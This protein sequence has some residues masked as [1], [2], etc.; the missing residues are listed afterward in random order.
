MALWLYLHTHSKHYGHETFYLPS[1]HNRSHSG[2]RIRPGQP[3]A[4]QTERCRYATDT[5]TPHRHRQPRQ[6]HMHPR[7]SGPG[8]LRHTCTAPSARGRHYLS[9]HS[10]PGSRIPGNNIRRQRR[11]AGPHRRGGCH[12]R[13]ILT[14]GHAVP[15]RAQAWR[16]GAEQA[17][18]TWTAI[19]V[20][21]RRGHVCQH[22]RRGCP[23]RHTHLSG[24][25][26]QHPP[27]GNP[28]S[29]DD[30]RQR[31]P[32]QGRGDNGAQAFSGNR[33]LSCPQRDCNPALR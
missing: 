23:R 15:T 5:C 11:T 13:D 17:P 31:Y 26:R 32:E 20:P 3:L 27:G 7:Q 22:C 28:G 25:L 10:V 24:G 2:L 30:H 4:R 6:Q 21:H 33:G 14:D 16:T 29:T 8:S 9:G 12:G 18:G 1:F 19:S